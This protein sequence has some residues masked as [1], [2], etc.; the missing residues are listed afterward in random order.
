MNSNIT[1]LDW[2]YGFSP[3]ET[4]FLLQ[5]CTENILPTSHYFKNY[6]LKYGDN[7]DD[8]EIPDV[9]LPDTFEMKFNSKTQILHFDHLNTSS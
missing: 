2:S 4:A 1:E 9:K 7:L 3:F 5:Y 6:Q 8:V